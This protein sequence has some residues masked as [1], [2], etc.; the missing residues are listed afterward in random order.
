MVR[1]IGAF[2]PHQN[3]GQAYAG[4]IHR[5][6]GQ[7]GQAFLVDDAVRQNAHGG[8][9][10]SEQGTQKVRILRVQQNIQFFFCFAGK[11]A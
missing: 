8:S 7:G 6:S 2:Q 11:P 3:G 9:A 1:Q 4:D 10:V 5:A